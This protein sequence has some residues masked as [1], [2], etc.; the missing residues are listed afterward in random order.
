MENKGKVKKKGKERW[1]T[2]GEI[3]KEAQGLRKGK[4]CSRA[5]RTINSVWFAGRSPP[6]RSD[7]SLLGACILHDRKCSGALKA[8]GGGAA[9]SAFG[10]RGE[11][12]GEKPREP[13]GG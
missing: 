13:P 2:R 7:L 8:M 6:A 5:E 4:E 3:Q 12:E 10:D 11:A 9:P 1:G